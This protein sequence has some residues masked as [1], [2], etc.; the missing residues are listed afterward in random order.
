MRPVFRLSGR[1]AKKDWRYSNADMHAIQ[2]D[3]F[4]RPIPDVP[5][6]FQDPRLDEA[7]GLSETS[8][9]TMLNLILI[10]RVYV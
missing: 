3:L 1:F 6:E 10:R 9:R 2:F 7:G 4:R 8:T 5:A